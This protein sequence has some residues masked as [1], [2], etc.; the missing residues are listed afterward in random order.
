MESQLPR[1]TKAITR[2]KETTAPILC[3]FKIYFTSV[4]IQ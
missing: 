4:F 2:E 1:I 3:E